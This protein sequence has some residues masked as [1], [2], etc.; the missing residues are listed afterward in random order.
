MV[1]DSLRCQI[2]G[3]FGYNYQRWQALSKGSDF[4]SYFHESKILAGK[5]I[6]I[7][8]ALLFFNLPEEL[9]LHPHRTV[10][11]VKG[12]SFPQAGDRPKHELKDLIE[13]QE[14]DNEEMKT[15]MDGL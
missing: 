10:R 5:N 8:K 13:E 9:I 14:S 11:P 4:I 12:Y 15:Q 1:Q 3:V 7:Y 2:V 6:A